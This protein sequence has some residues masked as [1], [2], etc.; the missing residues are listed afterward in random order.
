M[1]KFGFFSSQL[2]V[3]SVKWNTFLE[4]RIV[5]VRTETGEER[6]LNVISKNVNFQHIGKSDRISLSPW[7]Q[8]LMWI[9][10]LAIFSAKVKIWKSTYMS[11]KKVDFFT[12][13]EN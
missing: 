6:Y 2:K 12:S 13:G 7:V 4:T 3:R 5:E 10:F 9:A 1:P 11:F 8:I